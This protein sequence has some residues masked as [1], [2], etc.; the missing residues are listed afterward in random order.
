MHTAATQLLKWCYRA[1]K[2]VQNS[3]I[4]KTKTSFYFTIWITLSYKSILKCL[5]FMANLYRLS[6]LCYLSFNFSHLFLYTQSATEL[7]L[8]MPHIP[9]QIYL[10][11][12][13]QCIQIFHSLDI[14][15][16]KKI[17]IYIYIY[18]YIINKL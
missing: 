7:P 10:R 14:V 12:N 2:K 17:Y 4:Q 9:Y 16:L 1:S 13:I 18:I 8:S 5:Y 3:S 11:E 6:K 15:N